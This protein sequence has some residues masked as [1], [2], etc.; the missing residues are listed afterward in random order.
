[1]QNQNIKEYTNAKSIVTILVVI[2]H[3]TR[4]YTSAG[5]IPL[6]ENKIL[7]MITKIIYLFHM[8]TFMFFSGAIYFQCISL[9]KYQNYIQMLKSKFKRLVIPYLFWGVVYV[10]PVM[11]A[12]KI[13]TLTYFKYVVF[14]ILLGGDARHLWYLWTLFFILCFIGI[15]D[16]IIHRSWNNKLLIL[17]FVIT[18]MISFGSNRITNL[19]C[20]NYFMR[21]CCYFVLG[22]IAN[23]NRGG[24]IRIIRMKSFLIASLI[25]VCICC[26]NVNSSINALFG[27]VFG[28]NCIYSISVYLDTIITHSRLMIMVKDNAMGIYILHPMIIYIWFYLLNNKMNPFISCIGGFV[29]S[30]M[31][32]ML[33]SIFIKKIRLNILFGE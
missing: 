27:A 16:K 14:G 31:L 29:L 3:V 30:F 11:V 18:G 5:A 15:I 10:A 12:L 8:P 33:G 26:F 23:L 24:I 25:I 6:G 9:G 13:T 28:I 21:Y 4:M 20:L 32:S 17:M 19:F 22:M 2:G 7:A 1:M